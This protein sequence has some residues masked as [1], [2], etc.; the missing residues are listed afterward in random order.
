M[1]FWDG[2][3]GY[4]IEPYGSLWGPRVAIVALVLEGGRDGRREVHRATYSR[5]AVDRIINALQAAL[6]PGEKVNRWLE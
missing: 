5:P 1:E 6:G 4:L 3:V 2:N